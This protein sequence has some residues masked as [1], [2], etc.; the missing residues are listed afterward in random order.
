MINIIKILKKMHVDQYKILAANIYYHHKHNINKY[1]DSKEILMIEG[2][3]EMSKFK[4]NGAEFN[5]YKINDHEMVYY[6]LFQE[7]KIGKLPDCIYIIVDKIEKHATLHGLTYDAKCFSQK[8]KNV[9]GNISGS[10]LLNVSLGVLKKIQKHYGL[11]YCTLLDN[12]EKK[13]GKINLNF[14]LMYTLINGDTW[15]GS[16]GF[17]PK[18][19]TNEKI[20][21]NLYEVYQNNKKIMDTIL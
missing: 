1:F 14:P 18:M 3:H 11:K 20:D 12:S 19:S 7:D 5:F 6:H 21:K 4:V 8:N 15:Y 13:C 10:T 2:G 17:V 9:Y 16:R